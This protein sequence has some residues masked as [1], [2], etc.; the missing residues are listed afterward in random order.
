M[1]MTETDSCSDS[2]QPIAVVV[3]AVDCDSLMLDSL[4]PSCFFFS[5]FLP[6]TFALICPSSLIGGSLDHLIALF[7]SVIAVT[8]FKEDLFYLEANSQGNCMSL[9]AGLQLDH[10]GHY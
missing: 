7:I 6:I 3:V 5:P 2:W 10:P 9:K 1:R 8:L 4:S